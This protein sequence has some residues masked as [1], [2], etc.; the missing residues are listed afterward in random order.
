MRPYADYAQLLKTLCID[1]EFYGVGI[2]INE[3]ES[4]F[5][6]IPEIRKWKITA[7]SQRPDTISFLAQKGFHIVAAEKGPGSVEDGIA[8]LRGFEEI[9]IHPK[10]RGAVD[11]FNNYKWKTDRITNEILPIPAAGS[12][13]VPDSLRY[14]LEPYIKRKVSIFDIDYRNVNLG[15]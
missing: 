4:A 15:F 6:T 7:D 2:E 11:N 13:H 3:L 9:I 12:D 1:Y 14:A 10:C 5:D 8:F